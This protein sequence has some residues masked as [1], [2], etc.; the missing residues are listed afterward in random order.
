[1]KRIL[2]IL[3]SGLGVSYGA[4]AATTFTVTPDDTLVSTIAYNNLVAFDIFQDNTTSGTINL[5]WTRVSMSV[6]PTWDYSTCDYNTCYSGIPV[7]GTMAQVASGGQGFLAL[8]LNPYSDAGT[9][10][11]RIY[12]YDVNFPA[13]GDTLTWIISTP[14]AINEYSLVEVELYPN[15]ANDFVTLNTGANQSGSVQIMDLNGKLVLTAEIYDRIT[16]IDVSMLPAGVY[17]IRFATGDHSE[18]VKELV[19]TR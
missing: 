10:I 3:L 15:P 16:R 18:A 4:N 13:Q 17:V 2:L 5:A 7:S 19:I 12:V 9:A 14:T 11:V 8:N 6:P 1:M